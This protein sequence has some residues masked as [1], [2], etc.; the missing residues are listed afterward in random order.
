[1]DWS[2]KVFFVALPIAF[3]FAMLS[4]GATNAKNVAKYGQEADYRSSPGM[5]LLG[6]A[7]GGV[8]WAAIIT[9]VIG[10]F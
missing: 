2:W 10:L 1:M 8:L 3:I 7:F 9:A 6:S 4:R 5:A